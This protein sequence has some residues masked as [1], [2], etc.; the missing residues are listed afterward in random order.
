MQIVIRAEFAGGVTLTGSGG[1]KFDSCSWLQWYGFNH[2]HSADNQNG[3]AIKW[4]NYSH[5]RMARCDL[6]LTGADSSDWIQ[7]KSGDRF[8]FDHNFVHDKSKAGNFLKIGEADNI[9]TNTLVQWNYFKNQSKTGGTGASESIVIGASNVSK[10]SFNTR[11]MNNVFE[12]C[13]ADTDIV[14]SKSCGNTFYRNT[15]L[16]CAGSLVLRHGHGLRHC[17][18]EHQCPNGCRNGDGLCNHYDIPQIWY[19]GLR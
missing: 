6:D 16:N 13:N 3:E 7:L 9:C 5:C 2:R 11:V 19:R 1:W 10:I 14:S 8:T 18:H 17:K 12:N 15:F 4:T